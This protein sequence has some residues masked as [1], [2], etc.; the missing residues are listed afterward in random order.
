MNTVAIATPTTPSPA[1]IF[2]AVGG[3]VRI[4]QCAN[5]VATACAAAVWHLHR[6]AIRRKEAW[7]HRT[8]AF[9]LELLAAIVLIAIFVIV[10][11]PTTS[12]DS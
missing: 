8:E 9:V 11:E 7:L 2:R 6:T 12:N 3:G 4:R 5:F 1:I 10:K